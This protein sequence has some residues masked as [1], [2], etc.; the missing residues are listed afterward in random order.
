MSFV[1]R[2][3]RV[4]GR[5]PRSEPP[6]RT[7]L[8]IGHRGASGYRPEHTL[9]AYRLAVEQGA[10]RVEPDLVATKDGVLVARHESEITDTTDVA[11]RRV[12]AG[13]RTIRTIGG[14][15]VEGWFTE[16]FMLEELKSLRTKERLPEL[17]PH[18]ARFDGRFEIATFEEI[19]DLLEQESRRRG[20]LVG[21]CPELKTPDYFRSRGLSLE[22][23]LVDVL[24]RRGLNRPNAPVQV[25]SFHEGALRRL[26]PR[27]RVPLVQLVNRGSA[28]YDA[29]TP[30]RLRE[31]STYAEILGPHRDLVLGRD[32]A[33]RLTGPTG[34]VEQAHA[35]GIT[36]HVW[37]LRNENRFLP[38][39]LRRGESAAAHG[40]A[41]AEIRMCLDAGVDGFFTDHPDTGVQARDAWLSRHCSGMRV[42]ATM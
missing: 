2:V 29:L 5:Q 38:A 3:E 40:D 14:R 24:E 27:L 17:R 37:T 18:S 10:D 7:P 39:E 36:V 6:L 23:P 32:G 26:R 16:D 15:T 8:V 34:L 41:V 33:G 30:A 42:Q 22:D 31:I 12:F 4:L 35:A 9:D 13:R 28:Q 25:Q 1:K 21:V 19:L 20:V 11:D